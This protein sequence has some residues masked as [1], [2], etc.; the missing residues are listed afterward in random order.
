MNIIN[1]AYKSEIENI[2][3]KK[4]GIELNEKKLSNSDKKAIP[5]ILIKR[6]INLV[7][8]EDLLAIELIREIIPCELVHY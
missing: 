1:I 4:K 5:V 2:L 8:T 3:E 6:L 7:F